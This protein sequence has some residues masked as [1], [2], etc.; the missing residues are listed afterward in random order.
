MI[1]LTGII[2]VVA[3]GSPGPASFFGHSAD[4]L[5]MPELNCVTINNTLSVVSGHCEGNSGNCLVGYK[6]AG[7][8][9][10]TNSISNTLY[11]NYPA[12]NSWVCAHGST[13]CGTAYAICCKY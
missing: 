13:T 8:G 12:T 4:E 10:D 9:C 3:F 5:E 11:R 2:V 6:L 7:G 1:V